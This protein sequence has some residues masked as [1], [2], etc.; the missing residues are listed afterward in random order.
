[1]NSKIFKILFTLTVLV[2]CKNEKEQLLFKNNNE[3]LCFDIKWKSKGKQYYGRSCVFKK[4]GDAYFFEYEL[5]GS[6]VRYALLEDFYNPPQWNKKEDSI[7]CGYYYY[8]A[9]YQN[10]KELLLYGKL[11]TLYLEEINELFSIS[12]FKRKSSL[13]NLI[14]NRSK[15][16]IA[17]IKMTN[18]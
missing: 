13:I 6:Q 1:M 7:F 11:D 5:E 10:E 9:S 16:T 8:K 12:F 4:N 15:D 3:N 18:Q 17:K 14:D 2:G